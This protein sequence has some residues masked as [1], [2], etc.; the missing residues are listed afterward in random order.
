MG[1]P[2]D[3]VAMR[4]PVLVHWHTSSV[5]QRGVAGHRTRRYHESVTH[6]RP[7]NVVHRSVL[8]LLH[9]DGGIGVCLQEEQSRGAIVRRSICVGLGIDQQRGAGSVP[10]QLGL[11]GR[12]NGARGHRSLHTGHLVCFLTI[13]S[14]SRSLGAGFR[15]E[16]EQRHSGGLT[17][18]LRVKSSHRD[19]GCHGRGNL[20][21][22]QPLVVHLV[23]RNSQR[24]TSEDLNLIRHQTKAVLLI[25]GPLD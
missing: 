11:R 8:A 23:D 10:H 14:G 2:A 4:G 20:E 25:G 12:K 17:A 15:V 6:R 21:L 16:A 9:L 19:V 24:I 5:V 1:R 7:L 22:S 18:T 13:F 3:G